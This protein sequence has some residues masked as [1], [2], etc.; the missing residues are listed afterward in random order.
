[1]SLLR[2]TPEEGNLE[3][4]KKIESEETLC[5]GKLGSSEYNF[6]ISAM[7]GYVP[8]N[9][10]ELL[11]INAGVYPFE[12]KTFTQFYNVYLDAIAKLNIAAEWIPNNQGGFIESFLLDQ[13]SPDSIRVPL[14][15]LEPFYHDE[16]WSQS[17][18][19]KKVLVISPFQDSI[20]K[21]YKKRK[22]IW[23]E[24]NVLPDFD[25]LTMKIPF[26]AGI[27]EPEYPTWYDGLCVFKDQIEHIKP[28][29][30]MVGAGAWS[31][32][33]VAHCSDLGIDSIHTGGGT[34]IIF[35]IK[36][37]RWD[38]HD[39]I[40]TFFNDHWIRPKKSERP[41]NMDRM[42]IDNGDYW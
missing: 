19:G 16:P 5:A 14:R 37:G 4:K 27:S 10:A 22:K 31:L 7:S 13:Y 1:M 26:S 8:H 11:H 6:I 24:K 30:V 3:I 40:S 35:G 34:Q 29:F 18:E 25:L 2:L 42:K 17:L 12:E 20:E 28:D 39:V 33:L 41:K 21:Q 9:I 36:G 38:K 15:S 32:P 23:G